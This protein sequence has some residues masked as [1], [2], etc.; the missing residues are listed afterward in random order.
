MIKKGETYVVMGLLDP[1]SIAYSV[2]RDIKALGG[3]VIFTAQN[4]RL[5]SIFFDRSKKL[6][7]GEADDLR[8]EY[9]DVTKEEE[10]RDLFA[11]IGPIAG[12]VHSIGY[13]NPKTALGQEF[14]TDAIEDLKTSFHISCVSLAT[15]TRHAFPYMKSGGSIVTLS[16][17][18][19]KAFAYYNWMGVN[20][21]ALEALVR[22]L[23]RRHGKDLIRVNAISAGPLTTKAASSIPGFAELSQTWNKQSALPWDTINDKD[24]VAHA[25][26]FLL[27]PYSKKITGQVIYVDG[28]ASAI[29][30][31]LLPF[32]RPDS[33]TGPVI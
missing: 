17:E 25:V 7:E 22:G 8:I 28:G 29:G 6:K 4:E 2:G 1:D 33:Q 21:A 31:E 5:K 3:N 16:F 27:G 32:E 12:V 23:A 13:A 30:G 9:C 10:V 26:L 15:V 24:E 18:A 20:K 11:K 14:H 19:S